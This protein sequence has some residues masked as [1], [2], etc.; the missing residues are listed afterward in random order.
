[1]I[2][3]VVH[4]HKLAI[5][6]Y[7]KNIHLVTTERLRLELATKRLDLEYRLNGIT[8]NSNF[9]IKNADKQVPLDFFRKFTTQKGFDSILGTFM[10]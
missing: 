5:I 6:N 4:V 2:K 10:E 3:L 1:M 9:Y 8:A 7:V